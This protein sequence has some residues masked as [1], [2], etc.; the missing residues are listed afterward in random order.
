DLPVYLSEEEYEKIKDKIIHR[1]NNN[2]NSKFLGNEQNRGA[3]PGARLVLYGEYYTKQRKHKIT[4]TLETE[5]I[6]Y[7]REYREKKGISPKEI[8]K[9][10][11]KK[12]TASHW[13]RLDNGRSLPSPDDWIK[14][15]EIL[16]FDDKYDKIM[17]EQ[18]YVLQTV[19]PHPKGKNPGN[20]WQIATAKLKEA[21]FSVFP[22][23]LPR[24]IIEAC[25]PPNGLVLDPF[26]GSGTTGKVAKELNRR[27]ILIDIKEDYVQIIRKR[28]G[29]INI[30]KFLKNC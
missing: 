21:H 15:K 2:S 9:L 7:L 16:Q 6:K 22:E 24:R 17:T 27:S 28:C 19:K 26:A 1:K 18:H 3:S 25:C 30:K 11:N 5:I 23:E 4:S 10:L 29:K 12:D 13:F 8:D 14:L 20:V